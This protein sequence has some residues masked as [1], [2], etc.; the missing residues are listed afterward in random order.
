[1]T[2]EIWSFFYF[3]DFRRGSGIRI[4]PHYF[5]KLYP[6]SNLSEKLDPDPYLSQNSKALEAQNRAVKGR[7]NGGLEAQNGFPSL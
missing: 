2:L 1:M 4:D 3:H 5:W 7:Q 6:D